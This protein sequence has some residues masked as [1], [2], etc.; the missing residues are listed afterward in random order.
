MKNQSYLI[1]RFYNFFYGIKTPLVKEI[2]QLPELTIIPETPGDIIGVLYLRDR[3]IPVMHLDRR[4]GQPVRVCQPSDRII[5]IEWQSIEMGIVVSEVLDVLEIDSSLLEPEPNYGRANHINTAFVANIAAFF[6]ES[7]ILLD[8]E[9]LIRQPE[10]ISEA[11]VEAESHDSQS[12]ENY[13]NVSQIPGNFFDLYCPEATEKE[14]AIFR[15]RAKELRQPLESWSTEGTMP[16]AVFSLGEEYYGCDLEVVREF[17]DVEEVTPIPC[18]P[19]HIVGNINL[20]GE[21]VTLIDIR[22]VLH[23]KSE[24]SSTQAI[25]VE[26][27]DIHAGIM[28]DEIFDVF[29]ID[30]QQLNPAP[31]GIAE[32]IKK[33]FYGMTM[34]E[35]N[36]LSALD[37]PKMFAE[38]N[39]VVG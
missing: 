10:A 3:L 33:Y 34:Y 12:L 26:I 30:R 4:L 25:L 23:A 20:R 35:E 22:Y 1:F 2:F 18:C 21:I 5:L 15:Q 27:G 29:H 17:I 36:L 28:V 7:I 14:K 8:H 39:L 19:S 31:T 37:L 32:E 38:G 9:A 6:D 16:L 13:E 11:I 24:K